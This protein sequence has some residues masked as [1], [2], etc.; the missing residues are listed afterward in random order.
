MTAYV[1]CMS[2]ARP[3][4]TVTMVSRTQTAWRTLQRP[5]RD[6]RAGDCVN[7]ADGTYLQRS[8]WQPSHGGNANKT[9]GYVVYRSAH[10]WGA[11]IT[12][13]PRAFFLVRPLASF[14][15]L[16]GFELDGSG[17][18]QDAALASN[19]LLDPHSPGH[20]EGG[21]GTVGGSTGPSYWSVQHAR[22]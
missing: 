2:A 22:A 12:G 19:P 11:K 4:M 13:T 6:V 16:D 5:D 14:L 7:V 18:V 8:E 21:P 10:R 15:I 3:G 17:G 1:T 9:D 20:A